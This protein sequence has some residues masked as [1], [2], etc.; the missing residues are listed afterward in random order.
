LC[1]TSCTR[2]CKSGFSFVDTAIRLGIYARSGDLKIAI[3]ALGVA[4]SNGPIEKR[5]R[6]FS[7]APLIF[8]E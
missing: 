2:F 4:I 6:N 8:P 5:P 7:R 1:G 3:A